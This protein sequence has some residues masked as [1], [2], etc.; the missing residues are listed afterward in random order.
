MANEG[1]PAEKEFPALSRLKQGFDSPRERHFSAIQDKTAN[2]ADAGR[3]SARVSDDRDFSRVR[4]LR[5]IS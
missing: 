1:E 5:I 4:S 3:S 2:S